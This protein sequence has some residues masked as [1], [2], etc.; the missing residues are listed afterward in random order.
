[1]P[2][3]PGIRCCN[4]CGS[5]DEETG[6]GGWLEMFFLCGPCSESYARIDGRMKSCKNA[7][8]HGRIRRQH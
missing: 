1:M 7:T 5:H 4:A 8:C 3:E 2:I 6:H